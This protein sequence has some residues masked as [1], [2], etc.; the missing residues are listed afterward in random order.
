M[1][2][3]PQCKVEIPPADFNISTDVA[4]CRKC[5]QAHSF[6][7]LLERKKLSVIDLDRTPPYVRQLELREGR[8]VRYRKISSVFFFLIPFTALWSGGLM[9]GLYRTVVESG[10]TEQTLFFLPFFLGTLVLLTVIVFGLFGRTELRQMDH[11]IT[12]F[13]GVLGVGYWRR[14]CVEEV[15]SVQIAES[16]LRQNSR[17]LHE[18][19]ITLKDDRVIKFGCFMTDA[20]RN[21]FSAY[22]RKNC[23]V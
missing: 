23:R 2:T 14:F 10:F 16:S 19:Q 7:A 3:C 21:Y 6:S 15:R 17:V 4:F 20:A 5:N 18:V 1:I 12:I 9:Y 11:R 22:L 8:G 13:T